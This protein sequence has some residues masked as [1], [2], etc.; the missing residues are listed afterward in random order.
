MNGEVGSPGVEGV[1]V[2]PVRPDTLL[3]YE[4]GK[5]KIPFLNFWLAFI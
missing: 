1:E 2:L 4:V 5:I 3:M